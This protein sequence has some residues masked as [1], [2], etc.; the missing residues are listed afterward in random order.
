MRVWIEE[1]HTRSEIEQCHECC[2]RAGG[3]ISLSTVRWPAQDWQKPLLVP[4][5]DLRLSN[6]G[7]LCFMRVAAG[8]SVGWLARGLGVFVNRGV[9]DLIGPVDAAFML[10]CF[11]VDHTAL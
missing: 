1:R 3:Y 6:K 7:A 5:P 8:E 2:K 10:A 11:L 9:L 4:V